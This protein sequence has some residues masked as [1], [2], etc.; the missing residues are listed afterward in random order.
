MR[1]LILGAGGIGGYFGA[2]IHDAGGDVSFL[3]RPLRA[4]NLM[5]E[6]LR[7][8]SPL[9]D[10]HFTPRVVTADSDL[11]DGYDVIFLSCK[12]YDLD[13]ALDAIAPAVGP[14]TVIVPLLNGIR[15]LDQLDARFGR[16]K[17]LGGLAHLSLKLTPTGE[18]QHLNNF[19]RLM[20]GSRT[21]TPSHWLAP[22]AELLGKTGVEFTLAPDIEQ[23]M[24]NKFV[25]ITT[26]AGATCAM[27]A[28]IGEI[29][30]TNAGE[31]FIL[32]LLGEC[33]EV[34]AANHRAPTAEQLAVYKG[35]L[36]DRYSGLVASMLRDIERGGPTEAEHIHGDMMRRGKLAGVQTP[37]L[38]FAYTH[39]QAYEAARK[40][41]Y[42]ETA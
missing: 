13:S 19:H 1:I 33:G 9:G 17:V 20:I 14:E 34:A 38:E 28:N 27:R 22:L 18:I 8:F 4:E 29:M 36:T 21:P 31:D 23:D 26:L 41:L 2:R 24:W 39:L 11:G 42:P 25:F 15:H 37:L 35:Q 30:R 6:G 5:A 32:G 10:S 40:R 3:V 7:V 12:A 16:E